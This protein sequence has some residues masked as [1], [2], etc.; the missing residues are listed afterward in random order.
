MD[1]KRNTYLIFLFPK[2]KKTVY[3]YNETVHDVAKL[4]I[5]CI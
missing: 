2:C 1:I 4:P 5:A 3:G